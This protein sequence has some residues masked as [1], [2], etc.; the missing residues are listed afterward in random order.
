MHLIAAAGCPSVVLFSRDSDPALTAP[1]GRS[2]TVLGRP[3]LADL[4]LAPVLAALPT[5]AALPAG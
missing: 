1:R 4:D 5:L 3:D 2:V